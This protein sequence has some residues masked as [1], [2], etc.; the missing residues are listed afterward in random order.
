MALKP[1]PRRGILPHWGIVTQ[2]ES[3]AQPDSRTQQTNCG[4]AEANNTLIF[5]I[6]FHLICPDTGQQEEIKRK[7]RSKVGVSGPDV[8]SQLEFSLLLYVR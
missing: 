8:G 6:I 3:V 1:I 4:V 7:I 2:T 5:R